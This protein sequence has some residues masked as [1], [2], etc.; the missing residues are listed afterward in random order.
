MSNKENFREEDYN[1]EDE[2]LE[3]ENEEFDEFDDVEEEEDDDDE[4]E[5]YSAGEHSDYND[6]MKLFFKEMGA[7]SLFTRE[8]EVEKAKEIEEAENKIFDAIMA[9][10][11]TLYMIS[12]KF[13]EAI[14]KANLDDISDSSDF[15]F[16]IIVD[17]TL[18]AYDEETM[19]AN[20][21]TD[22]ETQKRI[23][24]RQAELFDFIEKVKKEISTNKTL[25]DVRK[26]YKP[27][28]ELVELVKELKLDKKLVNEIINEIEK[29]HIAVKENKNN[30]IN[31]VKTMAGKQKTEIARR[32]RTEY[33]NKDFILDYIPTDIKDE[34]LTYLNRKNVPN[35]E[36][37]MYVSFVNSFK[38]AQNKLLEI[39][40]E[41]GVSLSTIG[42]NHANLL[43]GQAKSKRVK[44]EMVDANLRLVVSVAKKYHNSP[45]SIQLSDAI[46]EGNLGLIKAVDKFEYK[47]GFK[48]STYA[49]WWI[50]QSITRATADQSRVIRIPVHMVEN[51]QK[52]ARSRKKL[53]QLLEREPTA[54]ELAKDSGLS[55]DK[56]EK[57]LKVNKDPISM[58][59]PVGGDDDESR[60]S[61]F[62]EDSYGSKP[63]DETVNEALNLA[64]EQALESLPE[65]EKSILRMRFGFGVKSDY[66]LE[67][68]GKRFEVTRE[69]IRQIESKALKAIRASEFGEILEKFISD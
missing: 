58:E 22:E 19:K 52:I 64:L 27:N 14:E 12:D 25:K 53:K 46:Q 18:D 1:K 26:E 69:R 23:A 39:E 67:E 49:T 41:E 7:I 9:Y 5:E 62:I 31:I 65:R 63:H 36:V 29:I 11:K 28:L 44:K 66:T 35:S 47:R 48:F 33:A 17:N 10:P 50:K 68:V 60:I 61:D 55:E 43:Q 32:F 6:P 20:T 21:I 2:Y 3:T 24:A 30:A 13:D 45:N 40:K 56:V 37:G 51:I 54:E 16:G 34:V 4:S 59:T 15:C 42:K 8:E 57:A 38:E